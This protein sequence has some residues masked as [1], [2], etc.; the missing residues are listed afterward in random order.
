MSYKV[1]I[2]EDDPM[3]AMINEQYATKNP[4]FVSAGI[5]RNGKDALEFLSKNKV[6]LVVL[7]VYMPYMDGVETLK[8]IR[9][10]NIQTEVIMV[11]AANDTSTLEKTMNLGVV[12]YLVKPF[13]MERFQ[14]ALEKFAAKASAL[15]GNKGGSLD[16][17][18][19]DTIISGA[20]GGSRT[21]DSSD[22]SAQSSQ[23]RSA[24][25]K[26]IQKQTL[27]TIKEYFDKNPKWQ[28]GDIVAQKLGLSVVTVRH[29]L[30]YLVQVGEVAET[31][32]YETG[33]RPSMLYKKA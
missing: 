23:A 18:S 2:I 28:R 33:G 14:V 30:N 16:Q 6:D 15:R 24:Y 7:D 13:A 22:S 10:Q 8:K 21:A 17:S 12:D 25:P 9:E 26:G 29:Y 31:I 27:E 5:C 19:I 20:A 1:L 11:T 32:D 4:N 3:V